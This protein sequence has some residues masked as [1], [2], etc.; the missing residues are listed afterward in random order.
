MAPRRLPPGQRHDG[1]MMDERGL[2]RLLDEQTRYSRARAATYD[3]D[4]A[5]DTVHAIDVG[6][7]STRRRTAATR[8]TGSL[9][10]WSG[11]P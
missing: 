1:V 10:A 6:R 9:P 8:R 3:L 4:V 11:A 5:W 2:R 7:S